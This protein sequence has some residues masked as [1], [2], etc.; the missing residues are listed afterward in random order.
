MQRIQLRFALAT[1]LAL[2]I[3]GAF[4]AGV[5]LAGWG[6]TIV[7]LLLLATTLISCLSYFHKPRLPTILALEQVP[8]RVISQ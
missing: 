7:A 3:L 6:L 5:G 8:V 1:S 2:F 4:L